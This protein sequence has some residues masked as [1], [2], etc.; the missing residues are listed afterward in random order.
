MNFGL[1]WV[2]KEKFVSRFES[3]ACWLEFGGGFVGENLYETCDEGNLTPPLAD[4]HRPEE[5]FR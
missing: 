2:F 5:S 4:K 1:N 3:V